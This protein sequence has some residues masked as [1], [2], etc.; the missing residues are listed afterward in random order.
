MHWEREAQ[1][2]MEC[3]LKKWK[4][5]RK[6]PKIH[7]RAGPQVILPKTEVGS[8]G[9]E[10]PPGSTEASGRIKSVRMEFQDIWMQPKES[11]YH[12]GL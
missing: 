2:R 10:R 1:R 5:D 4:A 6:F 11:R 8:M 9:Q 3:V 7:R 12:R